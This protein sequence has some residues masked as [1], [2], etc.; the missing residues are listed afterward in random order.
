MGKPADDV[1]RDY[2][3]DKLCNLSMRLPLALTSLL[4][5]RTHRTQF[6][7]HQDIENKYESEGS[8][9][10][11]DEYVEGERGLSVD[12]VALTVT[13]KPDYVAALT[14]VASRHCGRVEKDRQHKDS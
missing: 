4:T 8:Q 7:D 6:D 11:E 1:D 5:S 9:E 13:K 10:S 3:E 2:G 14:T 12:D